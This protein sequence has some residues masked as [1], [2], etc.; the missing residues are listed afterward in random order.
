MEPH[1]MNIFHVIYVLHCTMEWSKTW[2]KLK[3]KGQWD[4]QYFHNQRLTTW[5]MCYV[6]QWNGAKHALSWSWRG[7]GML[8][9]FITKDWSHGAAS[10]ECIPCGYV[11]CHTTEWSKTC[12][13][14]SKLK[15]QWDAQYFHNQRPTTWNETKHVLS[16][17]QRCMECSILS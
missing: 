14:K 3:L 9:T 16:W 6:I 8:N 13:I 1:H 4:A 5:N 7:N 11:L 17:S 15:G 10:H 2:I 12:I